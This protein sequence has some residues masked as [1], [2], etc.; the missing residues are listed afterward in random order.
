MRKAYKVTASALVEAPAEV[1]YNILADYH[2]GHP[3]VLPRKYFT[4]LAVEG[5]SGRGDGTVIRFGMRAFGKTREARAAVTEPEPG[6]VLVETMLDDS[7]TVTTFLVEPEGR[8]ARVTFT[9]ELR[10]AAGLRG[11]FE[12]FAATKYLRRV[13]AAELAQLAKVARA[14]SSRQTI[15]AWG[16]YR[17]SEAS[18]G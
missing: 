6:R 3:A 10:G 15:N 14:R 8:G 5:G 13:Y 7:G 1:V 2:E 11:L 9:T 16:G 17:L 12:R 18:K 4:G